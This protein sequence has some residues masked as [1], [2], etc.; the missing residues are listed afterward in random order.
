MIP[1]DE[2]KRQMTLVNVFLLRISTIGG[3]QAAPAPRPKEKKASSASPLSLR[4]KGER[5]RV[6]C[7]L[8]KGGKER[9][10]TGPA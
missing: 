7:A 6:A 4:R 5:E 9:K 1:Y 2:G 8:G 10:D 3:G